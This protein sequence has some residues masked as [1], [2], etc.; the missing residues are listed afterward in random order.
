MEKFKVI[1]YPTGKSVEVERGK[2][3]LSAAISAG[4]YIHSSCGGEG[5]CGRCKV[6]L[7][8][9]KVASQPTGKLSLEEKQKGYY[10]ACLATVESD[11]EI[12]IPSE[13][14]VDLEKVTAEELYVLRLK[15]IYEKPKVLR[16][17]RQ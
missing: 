10:L 15:G 5:V 2:T 9:G 14:R 6:I 16:S 11:L 13:S 3:I 7:K 12:E 1:F 4:V 17:K 8:K